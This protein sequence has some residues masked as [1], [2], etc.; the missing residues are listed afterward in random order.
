MCLAL[1]FYK[2]KIEK[3]PILFGR[4][5]T[6]KSTTLDVYKA[7]LGYENISSEPLESLTRTDSSG[8]FSRAMLDGKLVNIASDIGTRIADDG[9]AKMLISREAISAARKC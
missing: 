9:M 7:L 1:P 4:R 6:G 3:A 2:G 8:S 5:D